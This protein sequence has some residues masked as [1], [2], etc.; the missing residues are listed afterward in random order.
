L[1]ALVFVS[2]LLFG[3]SYTHQDALQPLQDR[4][5]SYIA[6]SGSV[7]PEVK[8]GVEQEAREWNKED[9]QLRKYTWNTPEP[10]ESLQKVLETLT[11]VSFNNS[12]VLRSD[13]FPH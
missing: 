13:S 11:Q 1:P 2:F 3:A 5:Q 12:S 10:H 8:V 7:E 9:R 4:L 6:E